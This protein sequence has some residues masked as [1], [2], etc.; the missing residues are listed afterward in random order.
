MQLT[1]PETREPIFIEPER[2]PDMGA[3]FEAAFA[4][5]EKVISA[6]AALERH[7]E[8]DEHPEVVEAALQLKDSNSVVRRMTQDLVDHWRTDPEYEGE[9]MLAGSVYNWHPG[10]PNLHP[11]LV[12]RPFGEDRMVYYGS[13]VAPEGM[14]TPGLSDH[15]DL[16]LEASM[17]GY[18]LDDRSQED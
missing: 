4:A 15:I 10:N 16:I 14:D 2:A 17:H 13:E 8:E 11:A 18:L 6:R 7:A 3:F 5:I 9:F 1:G 12:R